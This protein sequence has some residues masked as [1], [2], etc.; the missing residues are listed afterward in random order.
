[1]QHDLVKL[2]IEYRNTLN[3]QQVTT[4][5]CLDQP[6]YALSK[7]IQWKYIVWSTSH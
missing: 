7:I 6:I 4:V 1:M 2:C 3:H 5:N